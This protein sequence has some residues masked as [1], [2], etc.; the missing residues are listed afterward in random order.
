MPWTPELPVYSSS[1]SSDEDEME[2]SGMQKSLLGEIM[3]NW[4]LAD[5]TL[6]DLKKQLGDADQRMRCISINATR[7]FTETLK[8]F[9]TRL[10]YL[11]EERQALLSAITR[12]NKELSE[13]ADAQ[14]DF[15]L[16][17]HNLCVAHATVKATY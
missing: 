16:L 8:D 4:M 17:P 11:Q 5:P 2:V 12:R 13:M 3:R 9:S 14:I 6:I 7:D 15:S 1:T 10:S